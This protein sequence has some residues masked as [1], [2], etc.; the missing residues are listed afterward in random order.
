MACE[1]EEK[2]QQ[3]RK[4]SQQS[5][6]FE[7]RSIHYYPHSSNEAHDSNFHRLSSPIILARHNNT[8]AT[9]VQHIKGQ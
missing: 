1:V 9:E 7:E 2:E 4:A 5:P 3:Q 8:L 6:S